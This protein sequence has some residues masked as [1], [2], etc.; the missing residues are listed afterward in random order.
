MQ[1][2]YVT[3]PKVVNNYTTPNLPG[4]RY[5]GAVWTLDSKAYIYGGFGLGNQTH[6]IAAPASYL[7]D[8]W[9]FENDTWTHV[10]G[11]LGTEG[12]ANYG[13]KGVAAST[14]TPGARSGPMYQGN[15]IRRMIFHIS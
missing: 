14:N 9:V 7:G 4:G 13:T 11:F 12:K 2:H 15:L 6:P 8:M 1:W 3:G 10:N 5:A